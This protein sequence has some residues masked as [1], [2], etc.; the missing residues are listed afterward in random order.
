MDNH[1][2]GA[3]S[4]RFR[5]ATMNMNGIHRRLCSSRRWV[6][7]VELGDDALEIGPG[8]GAT[9]D[10]L[11]QHTGKLTVLEYD[12]ELASALQARMPKDRV[13]VV[14]GDGTAMPFED[15]RFSSVVC[16]TM[17]HHIP[18]DELQD[19]LF[20][21]ARRVLRPG[22]VFTGSDSPGKNPVFWLIHIGNINNPLHPDTLGDRLRAAGFSRVEVRPKPRIWWRAYA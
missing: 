21:E 7:F 14:N 19:R 3:A 15:A 20:A 1:T 12:A 10:V 4:V 17:L 18:T 11:R 13:T 6:N 2:S 9:T 5:M 8:P 22:G 16:F